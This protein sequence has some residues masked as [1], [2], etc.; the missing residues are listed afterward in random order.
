MAIG[1]PR[2]KNGARPVYVYDPGLGRKVY[3]GSRVKLRGPGGAQELEREKQ[4]EF[5]KAPSPTS[6]LTVRS[7]ASDWLEDHHGEGTRRPARATQTHNRDMLRAFLDEFGHLELDGGI[8]RRQAL[9]WAKTHPHNA[10]A[11]SAMFNDAID[12]EVCK[13]ANPFARRRQE[14]SR[15]RKHIHPLT[16]AEVN[17]LADIAHRHWGDDGYG[18]AARAW[19][20]FAAWVGCRPGETFGS[21]STEDLDFERGE[22]TIRRVKKRGKVYPTDV[23]VFPRAAQDAVRAMEANGLRLPGD[24]PLFRTVTGVVMGKG[25]L[26]YHW[27]PIRSAFRETVS[28]QRWRE[29]LDDSEDKKTFD[30]YVL[31]HFCASVMADRGLNAKQ[32]AGQLGNSEAVC[33]ETYIHLYRDRSNDAVRQAL[34]A[35]PV[36]DLAEVRAQKKGA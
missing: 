29:L 11:V 8:G 19:V 18:W 13:T 6:E 25:G 20:L 26:R 3:V 2:G 7:Y 32:I 27:E 28:A 14:E 12:D 34:E 21:I 17:R 16:E 33:Q 1:R 31:R 35:A 4:A 22:V 15:E 10:K 5:A 9:R 36:V 30:F 24:G 23:V